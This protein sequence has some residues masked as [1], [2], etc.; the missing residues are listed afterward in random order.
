MTAR[1][2]GLERAVHIARII[3]EDAAAGVPW[4]RT[5]ADVHQANALTFDPPFRREDVDRLLHD[6]N[7]HGELDG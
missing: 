4:A 6:A 1:F 5:V 7:P 3:E 2:Q